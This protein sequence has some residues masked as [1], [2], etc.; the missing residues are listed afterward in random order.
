M[1]EQFNIT[2]T[3]EDD[4]LK[5]TGD[6]RLREILI[7]LLQ[8]PS[9]QVADQPSTLSAFRQ[10]GPLGI[11]ERDL[12]AQKKPRGHHQIVAVLALALR[13]SG[14]EEF[15]ADEMRRAYTRAHQRQPKVMAQ[16]LRDAKNKHELLETGS[17][18]NT[19]RLS[20][21]GERTVVFD[22]PAAE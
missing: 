11:S 8:A 1:I 2:V 7:R 13:E 12:I 22:L 18:K 5:L 15:T 4:G 9:E 21:H 3:V 14:A 16:A 6:D 10:Q 17:K 19:F 20:S